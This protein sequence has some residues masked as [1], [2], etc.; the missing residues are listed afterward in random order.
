MPDFSEPMRALGV[1]L[2][3]P[4]AVETFRVVG[5][6]RI[7]ELELVGGNFCSV[8]VGRL[9]QSFRQITVTMQCPTQH[10]IVTDH[11]VK[12]N[13]FLERAKYYEESPV[14]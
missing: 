14:S 7:G 12:Q 11:F 6:M 4:D 3:R 5:R 2:I 1:F 8:V 9:K 13:V 10:H